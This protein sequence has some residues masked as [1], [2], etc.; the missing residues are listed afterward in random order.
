[1]V[2][3]VAIV[4]GASQ[5]LGAA[6]AVRLASDYE[7]IV[8]TARNEANLK[9]TASAIEKAGGKALVVACDL[10]KPEAAKEVVDRTIKEFGR[11]DALFNNAGAVKP[12]NLFEMTDEQW[13]DGFALK[14]HGARRLTLHAW[15]HLKKTQGAVLFMAGVACKT[16]KAA[17][18][19]VGTVNSAVIT[20]AKAFADQGIEDGI[21]VN[22]ILP[23]PVETERLRSMVTQFAKQNSLSNDEAKGKF[24]KSA[25]IS[26]Y[27]RA[28]EV[29]ELVA[30]MLSPPAR[31]IIGSCFSIDGGQTKGW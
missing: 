9:E 22:S 13:D 3:S 12:I 31:W 7:A 1:M 24:L 23:G 11:I 2:K 10:T 14:L 25:G 16:P 28:D 30:Y 20:L 15:P 29:A 8:V 27:G 17:N 19:A 4:T 21:Q 18:V 26:R 6:S 5:G